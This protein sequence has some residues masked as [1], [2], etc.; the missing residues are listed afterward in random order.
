M[1]FVERG[2]LSLAVIAAAVALT[3]GETA[4]AQRVLSEGIKD[5]A[6]QISSSV[7]QQQKRKIAVP[8]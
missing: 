5:L 2:W 3:V 6:S 8:P 1:A 4:G 7:T